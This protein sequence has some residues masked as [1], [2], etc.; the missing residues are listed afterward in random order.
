MSEDT[1]GGKYCEL[2]MSDFM[3]WQIIRSH[4]TM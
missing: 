2:R 1:E 3:P 4:P